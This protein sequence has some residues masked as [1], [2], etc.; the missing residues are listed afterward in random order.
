MSLGSN[1][2]IWYRLVLYVWMIVLICALC[3]WRKRRLS[4]S[5]WR[6]WASIF[7]KDGLS[8]K[9]K[10]L[11]NLDSVLVYRAIVSFS[12][13]ALKLRYLSS[14]SPLP[15]TVL[16]ILRKLVLPE[17]LGPIRTFTH[18]FPSILK[19]TVLDF[20]SVYG[21]LAIFE[22]KTDFICMIFV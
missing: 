1:A 21:K 8:V 2:G 5:C 18:S 13:S 22:M 20:S 17:P 12:F 3:V 19:K 14:M 9:R 11:A 10:W 15:T 4:L 16:M 7:T 6:T